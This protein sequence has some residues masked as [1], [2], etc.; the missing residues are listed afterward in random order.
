FKSLSGI[1]S[2]PKTQPAGMRTTL[3]KQ[4][5]PL[6]RD[7]LSASPGGGQYAVTFRALRMQFPG[8][9]HPPAPL[10]CFAPFS[11]GASS[12][13]LSG[14]SPPAKSSQLH[15]GLSYLWLAALRKNQL[16]RLVV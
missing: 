10:R 13:P 3:L 16:I 7:V 8:I 5:G 4:E 11:L 15:G 2:A 9:D 14:G 12:P 6:A 1:N